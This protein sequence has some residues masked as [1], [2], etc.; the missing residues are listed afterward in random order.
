MDAGGYHYTVGPPARTAIPRWRPLITAYDS[1]PGVLPAGGAGPNLVVGRLS[2]QIVHNQGP[3]PT[4]QVRGSIPEQ[5]ALRRP[6]RGSHV[7]P[8]RAVHHLCPVHPDR[9]RAAALGCV[10]MIAIDHVVHAPFVEGRIRAGP[11][12]L[13]AVEVPHLRFGKQP[14]VPV[15]ARR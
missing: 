9:D 4:R 7:A 12:E 5:Q 14:D 11:R 1:S 3:Q 2:E 15:R 10:A 8:T 6:V 13:L